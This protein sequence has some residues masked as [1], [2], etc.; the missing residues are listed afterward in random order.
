M[1]ESKDKIPKNFKS[2]E[3]VRDFWDNRSSADYWDEMEDADMEPSP[4]L[5]SKLE[6][7]RIYN[8][9][10]LSEKQMSGIEAEAKSE[11]TDGRQLIYR[12]ISEH[13]KIV[14]PIRKERVIRSSVSPQYKKGIKHG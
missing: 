8:L 7:K 9:L 5:R 14:S 4:A 3:D 1:Q 2:V 13:I 11:N 12:W 6:A 10:G